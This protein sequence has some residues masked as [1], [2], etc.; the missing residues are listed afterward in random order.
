MALEDEIK[1]AHRQIVEGQQQIVSELKAMNTSL[2]KLTR[3]AQL[4]AEYFAS[5]AAKDRANLEG[6]GAV[7][8]SPSNA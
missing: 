6:G 2:I 8:Q 7:D 5:R 4:L 3:T 1:A